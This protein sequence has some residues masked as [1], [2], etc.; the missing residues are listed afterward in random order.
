MGIKGFD[1]DLLEENKEALQSETWQRVRDG[2]KEKKEVIHFTSEK[3]AENDYG[4]IWA[5][6]LVGDGGQRGISAE[7]PVG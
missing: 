6:L 3:T 1:R 7:A 5:Y 2:M 4:R